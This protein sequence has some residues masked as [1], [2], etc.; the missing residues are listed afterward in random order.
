MNLF[1]LNSNFEI[2]KKDPVSVTFKKVSRAVGLFYL[3]GQRSSPT[4]PLAKTDLWF[5]VSHG[6]W[7]LACSRS[8]VRCGKNAL[9]RFFPEFVTPSQKQIAWFSEAQC[10]TAVPHSCN[11]FVCYSGFLEDLLFSFHHSIFWYI[12]LGR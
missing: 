3:Q 6:F 4:S 7:S 9:P 12:Y 1:L 5:T 8:S 10:D 2:C 11:L